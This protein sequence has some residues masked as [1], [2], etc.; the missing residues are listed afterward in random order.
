MARYVLVKQSGGEGV[1]VE[2]TRL[3]AE[4]H[5]HDA[6]T[7]HPE[8]LPVE[9]F[10]FTR[11]VVIGREAALASGYADLVLLDERGQVALVEVK[12]EG[13]PDTRQVV[14]QLIDYAGAM[15]GQSLEEFER[16]VL[17]PYA[18]KE[19][20]LTPPPSLRQFLQSR[21][22]T[23]IDEAAEAQPLAEE[24]SDV[25]ALDALERGLASTLESGRFT[26]VVA[27]P[28]IPPGV[29][30]AL[31]YLNAQGLHLFGVEVSYFAHPVEVFVPR[32][33]V[34]PPPEQH[35]S[36]S[37]RTGE[38]IDREAFL[39]ALP[40]GVGAVVSELLDQ[41]IERGA[42]VG[43][44]PT[45][46]NI[47]MRGVAG[48][49]SVATFEAKRLYLA[50]NP[51]S[52]FPGQPF[53]WFRERLRGLAIGEETPAGAYRRI[54][55]GWIKDAEE[56]KSL[57][58]AILEMCERLHPPLPAV[59]IQPPLVLRFVRND[60]NIWLKALPDLAT[61]RGA[62][63]WGDIRGDGSDD[64]ASVQLVPLQGDALGWVPRFPN[65][66]QGARI[67]P[68]GHNKGAFVLELD[69]V[70]SSAPTGDA[71]G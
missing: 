47:R 4:A 56:L 51:G 45:G 27:A 34:Q 7:K 58:G 48:R 66:A 39:G 65:S 54:D 18:T 38:P 29:R 63:L 62:N 32:V 33:V 6:L 28:E 35:A 2:E 52:G 11:A 60:Y 59:P 41:A 37:R 21:F 15:W 3:P 16:S 50:L 43:W 71:S 42:E 64:A 55:Y 9:D 53:E 30:R 1:C 19:L 26:L 24:N 10:G 40:P 12:K 49:A 46:P 17:R 57:Q 13:N 22:A 70:E 31:D 61:Y 5:L 20:G 14:A 67:W 36:G 25:D 68:A 69:Q 23:P 44:N 8:L